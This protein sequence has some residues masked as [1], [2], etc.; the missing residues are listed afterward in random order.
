MVESKPLA[1]VET[2]AQSTPGSAAPDGRSGR[3]RPSRLGHALQSLADAAAWVRRFLTEPDPHAGV[4][5]SAL[6]PRMPDSADWLRQLLLTF[7]PAYKQALGLAFAINALALLAAIFTMQVYDRVVGHAGYSTLMAL[8]VGMLWVVVV[9]YV[10]R[11]GRAV[12]LQRVGARL[13]V[14]IARAVFERLMHLPTLHLELRSPAFWQNTFRDVELVRATCAG[15]AALL[16]L[17]LPFLLLSLL[18]IGIIAWPV[19]PVAFVTMGAFAALAWYSGRSVESDSE[20]EKQ[21]AI[22][23]DLGL[24]ELAAAR[25]QLK[26]LG[27]A[28][29]ATTRWEDQYA[30]WMAE[31][32]DRSRESD[33]YRDLAVEMTTL[34]TV[35]TTSFGALAILAQLM[36]MGSLIAANILA[37]KLVSPLVQLVGHW[38]AW[39]QFLAAKKRLDDLMVLP[40]ERQTSDVQLPRPQGVIKL[41]NAGFSYPGSNAKQID[42]ISGQLGPYGLHAVVG[43]NGSG[44]STLLK[45][46]RGLYVPQSGRVLLD[47]A[48]MIQFSQKDLSRWIGYLPQQIQLVSGSV[49][50]NLTLSDHDVSDEQMVSAARLSCAHDFI[51]D[52]PDGYGTQVGDG[53]Q[54]FSGG[55]RKRIAI[56]QVLMHD[57]AVLL[58]DEPTSDLDSVAE[59]AFITTLK[60]LARDHTVIVVTHSPAV[61]RHCNGILVLDKG[62]M[63]AA[64]PAATILP[65]LG[66]AVPEAEVS[67]AA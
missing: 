25:V 47:G 31:S 7:R 9:D 53:G 63:V 13:E 23:R 35:V 16:L 56:A 40:L 38:R 58:L 6:A 26:S 42:N 2:A 54:R 33:K 5:G 41:E 20:R 29:A 43:A 44:K 17:D 14:A 45:L 4:T 55:Q 36:S 57:P 11:S 27:A 28:Q 52:L 19:L 51:V 21:K 49:K 61:L 60:N 46:L 34:N 39:G 1:A 8:V 48:D 10:L 64:G 15:A 30:R 3:G 59:Q 22:R 50:D 37:G 18:L 66:L 24:A 12:L 65:K 62:K 67:H 32:L